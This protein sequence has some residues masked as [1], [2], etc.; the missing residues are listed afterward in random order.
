M[1]THLRIERPEYHKAWDILDRAKIITYDTAMKREPYE[2]NDP[3]LEKY[4]KNK[5]FHH[6]YRTGEWMRN[7]KLRCKDLL[8][9]FF[10]EPNARAYITFML[11]DNEFKLNNFKVIC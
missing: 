5:K 4:N 10:T 6:V 1:H 11:S 7:S 9:R 3:D 8:N 2:S